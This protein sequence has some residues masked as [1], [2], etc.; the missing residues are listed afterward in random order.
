[1]FKRI[2][3]SALIAKLKEETLFKKCLLPDIKNGDIFPAIRN[4]Y[5]D[6]YYKGGCLFRYDGEFRTHIKY[7]SVL[8][9][10][11][12]YISQN[13]LSKAHHTS[14]FIEA[15][16]RIKENCSL[17][18]GI[19]RSS[20]WYIHKKY[21][22]INNPNIM[23]LDIEVSFAKETKNEDESKIGR[24][25]IDLLIFNKKEKTLRFYEA[26]HFSN[27]EIWTKEGNEPKVQKQIDRYNSQIKNNETEIIEEYSKYIDALNSLFELYLDKPRMAT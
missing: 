3:S 25:Q 18:S 7:A 26:K 4:K 1:M 17:Y 13:E 27:S 11:K 15:Y 10:L 9:H 8:D 5:I 24:D 21:S 23:V 16:S 14:N 6:F 19:E 2:L 12:D 22:Y 20:L